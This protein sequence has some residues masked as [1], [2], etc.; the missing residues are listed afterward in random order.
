MEA[1]LLKLFLHSNLL[2]RA[3]SNYSAICGIE[4]QML[5]KREK[6]NGSQHKALMLC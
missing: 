2:T 4:M 1:I 6:S 5:C 3:I